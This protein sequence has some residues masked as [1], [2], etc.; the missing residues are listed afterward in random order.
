MSDYGNGYGDEPNPVMPTLVGGYPYARADAD[1]E[2]RQRELEIESW[3]AEHSMIWDEVRACPQCRRGTGEFDQ[4]R[5]WHCLD[6][7]EQLTEHL[8]YRRW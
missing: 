7:L 2:R 8:A 4:P 3:K 5:W 6:H 1:E